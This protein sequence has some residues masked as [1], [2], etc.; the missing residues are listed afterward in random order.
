VKREAFEIIEKLEV[1]SKPRRAE[2]LK[3]ALSRYGERNDQFSSI[4]IQY[5]ILNLLLLLSESPSTLSDEVVAIVTSPYNGGIVDQND[6]LTAFEDEDN[7]CF[8]PS[9]D[10]L[11]EINMSSDDMSDCSFTDESDSGE[12]LDIENAERVVKG[13]VNIEE[14]QVVS[15]P[16]FACLQEE[17]ASV[18]L[19]VL[20][21]MFG[22]RTH[23]SLGRMVANL[24]QSP[25]SCDSGS[26]FLLDDPVIFRNFNPNSLG[27]ASLKLIGEVDF[28]A[29]AVPWQPSSESLLVR[30]ALFILQGYW[31]C[32]QHAWPVLRIVLFVG[33]FNRWPQKGFTHHRILVCSHSVTL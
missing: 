20:R 26:D 15:A 17:R 7:E 4:Q 25:I 28:S 2:A 21:S 31:K 11:E 14:E 30:H 5:S 13:A 23:V 27:P 18:S 8:A 24:A 9:K 19:K 22:D 29:A 6:T 3:E 10:W 32:S 16:V 1:H 33:S 12:L